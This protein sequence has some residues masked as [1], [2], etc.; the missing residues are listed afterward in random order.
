MNKSTKVKKAILERARTLKGGELNTVNVMKE[1][2]AAGKGALLARSNK[3]PEKAYAVAGDK[4]GVVVKQ[5]VNGTLAIKISKAAAIDKAGVLKVLAKHFE[6][7][8]FNG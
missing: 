7:Q 6:R 1:L 8:E 5:A 3:P 2:I 4:K